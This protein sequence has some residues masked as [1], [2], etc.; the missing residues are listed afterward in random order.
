MMDKTGQVGA[1]E[2]IQYTGEE[3]RWVLNKYKWLKIKI[4]AN[5]T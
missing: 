2:Y 3:R 4:T 1:S 5:T